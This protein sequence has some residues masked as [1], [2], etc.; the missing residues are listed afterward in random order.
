MN[1]RFTSTSRLLV[2]AVMFA[3][4]SITLAAG[5]ETVTIDFAVK[6]ADITHKASGF[7]RGLSTTEPPQEML[8]Q[9]HPALFRQPV[10]DSPAKYGALAIYPRA[11][12]LKANVL[13]TLSDGIKFDGKFP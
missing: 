9:L 11:T 12:T 13:A 1:M 3:L 7:A 2:V 10:F 4:A 8:S 5:K 6:E